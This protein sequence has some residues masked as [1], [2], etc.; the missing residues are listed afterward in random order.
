MARDARRGHDPVAGRPPGGEPPGS[1]QEP[2]RA[3]MCL[4]RGCEEV[5]H[6][7]G[8]NARGGGKMMAA[9]ERPGRLSWRM[10]SAYAS[11][12][13]AAALGLSLL[14]ALVLALLALPPANARIPL[15]T[16]LTKQIVPAIA[17]DLAAALPGTTPGTLHID[18]LIATE[19][20][21]VAGNV[22]AVALLDRTGHVVMLAPCASLNPAP[23]SPGLTCA[24]LTAALADLTP[25]RM[26]SLLQRDVAPIDLLLPTP[27]GAPLTLVP[28]LAYDAHTFAVFVVVLDRPVGVGTDAPGNIFVMALW[29]NLRQVV[30]PALLI[31]VLAALIAGAVVTRR[32]AQRLYAMA[33][34]AAAWSA[35]KLH[36]RIYDD[37]PDV[38]GHLAQDLN[39][40]AGQ[41]QSLVVA[42]QS[43]AVL[44]E[45]QRLA[46]ELHDAVKQHIFANALLVRAASK[47]IERDPAA[48]TQH[49]ADAAALADQAQEE[50][51]A[52]IA[53]LRPVALMEGGLAHALQSYLAD[54][55]RRTGISA[56][57]HLQSERATPLDVE[58]T[59]LRVA[60]EAL[61]NVARHSHAE[62]V[63][64]RLAW[65][66]AHVRLS[67]RD[68]GQG[69][70]LAR[71]ARGLGLR[72]MRERVEAQHG[73]LLI[74]SDAT[75][76]TV[77]ATLPC[78]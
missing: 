57:L 7:E 10:I 30:F 61:A 60:Q 71:P 23:G 16:A 78:A 25:L 64:V 20:L 17:P 31:T 76:T 54:W 77:T 44:E 49:L 40:M 32:L 1:E 3:R 75:G 6:T 27:G 50:L 14:L 18:P 38:I 66:D 5:W 70:D 2:L 63:E 65:D 21:Q 51:V 19:Q 59:L 74:T 48:A 68:D 47:Q 43:L 58:D 35:G 72:G 13:L 52:L 62:T 26:Q 53:A 73:Q 15:A 28:L 8:K 69:F 29:M 41:V 34:A 4:I 67:V 12:T 46:R 42:R 9:A 55:S 45:R 33:Q 56:D 11:A 22:R 36:T 24:D 39:G 37:R